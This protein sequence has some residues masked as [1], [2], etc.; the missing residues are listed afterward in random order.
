MSMDYLSWKEWAGIIGV[1]ALVAALT[2]TGLNLGKMLYADWAFLHTIRINTEQQ[3][4]P[5]APAP[6]K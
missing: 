3:A 5:S 1:T 2:W 6:Q 4:R